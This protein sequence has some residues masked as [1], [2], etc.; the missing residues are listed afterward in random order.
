ME[1]IIEELSSL[2][3]Q[4]QSSKTKKAQLEGR[5]EEQLTRLKEFGIKTVAEGNKKLETMSKELGKLET[6]IQDKF[7][8]LKEQ[9]EW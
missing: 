4:I 8:T 1:K 9:F 7:K 6:E 5:R 3:K 2:Q